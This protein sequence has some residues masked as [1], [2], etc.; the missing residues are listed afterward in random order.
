LTESVVN[1][2]EARARAHPAQE[3]Q[4]GASWDI[5]AGFVR[6]IET[7]AADLVAARRDLGIANV[8]HAELTK[9]LAELQTWVNDTAR[10]ET[11]EHL[12]LGRLLALQRLERERPRRWR[13]SLLT[14]MLL[15]YAAAAAG[16]AWLL[17]A[18]GF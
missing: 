9:C 11:I 1:L 12:Q 5:A 3:A 10:F 14:V 6:V 17:L 18:Q 16:L 13:S 8:E 15:I 2:E 7:L 4:A